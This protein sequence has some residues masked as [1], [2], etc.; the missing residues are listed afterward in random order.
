MFRRSSY[1]Q[2]ASGNA[3]TSQSNPVPARSGAFS[4]L[5]NSSSHP[6]SIS[7]PRHARPTDAD[8]HHSSSMSTSLGRSQPFA[9]YSTQL[10]HLHNYGGAPDAASPAFFV[11]SYL[12]GSKHAEKVEEVHKARMVA[13]REYRATHHPPNAGSLSTNSSSV[14]LH[15]MPPSHRGLTHEIIERTP[16]HVEEPVAP[17]PTRWN[18]ADKYPQMEI[19]EN[20]RQ[21]KFAGAQR[22]NDEAASV[23]ADYPMPRQCGIY[24][25]E[26]TVVSK[27]KD[28]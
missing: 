17:W 11:P 25:Y 15:K 20:G 9:S 12:V 4:H 27:G 8:G 6:H 10:G 21:A 24:Y 23:R 7:H 2:V 18:D 22:S 5:A 28:G 14:N 19:E 26:V 13:Q 1:A 3:G 16:V